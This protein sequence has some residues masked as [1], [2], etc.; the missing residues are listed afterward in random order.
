ME[1][2]GLEEDWGLEVTRR[3]ANHKMWLAPTWS[4]RGRET[5]RRLVHADSMPIAAKG[6]VS[7]C[8]H[9]LGA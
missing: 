3:C 6:N 8:V 4:H 5:R 9:K 7:D 2:G 1:D